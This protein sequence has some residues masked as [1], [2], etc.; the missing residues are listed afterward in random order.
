MSMAMHA[1]HKH[2]CAILHA[3]RTLVLLFSP[4]AM[5]I[6]IYEM[7]LS[8]ASTESLDLD[9]LLGV[10][11]ISRQYSYVSPYNLILK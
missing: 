1:M 10:F 6:F 7:I 8:K 2:A 3:T 11:L 4:I 9:L 5:C